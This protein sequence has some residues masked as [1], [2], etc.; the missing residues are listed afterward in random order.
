M[1]ALIFLEDGQLE[2]FKVDL[3][4]SKIDKFSIQNQVFV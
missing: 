2:C 1:V 4:H 3:K